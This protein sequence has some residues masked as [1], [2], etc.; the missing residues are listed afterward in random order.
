MSSIFDKNEP[1]KTETK[2]VT[3]DQPVTDK[4]EKPVQTV[5][6]MINK[7]KTIDV[8]SGEK[9]VFDNVSVVEFN[10]VYKAFNR[11]HFRPRYSQE[12][13]QLHFP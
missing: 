11:Q 2:S 1:K 5:E 6:S 13:K 9:I 4:V 8:S 12:K 3:P 10:Q 7:I